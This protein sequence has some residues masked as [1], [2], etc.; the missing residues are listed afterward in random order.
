MKII[1]D[2]DALKML[3]N[4]ITEFK[5]PAII[6]WEESIKVCFKTALVRRIA[7]I[8]SSQF[9]SRSDLKQIKDTN[10]PVDVYIDSN[11]GDLSTKIIYIGSRVDGSEYELMIKKI[12]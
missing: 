6:M 1:A 3:P 12:V 11:F 9:E 8:E 2:D 10:T 7:L 5:D 4:I